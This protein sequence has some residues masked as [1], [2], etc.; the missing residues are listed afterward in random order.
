MMY[1]PSHIVLET[2]NITRK[3][4]NNIYPVSIMQMLRTEVSMVP[5]DGWDNIVWVMWRLCLRKRHRVAPTTVLFI[6]VPPSPFIPSSP[7]CLLLLRYNTKVSQLHPPLQIYQHI[8]RLDITMQHPLKMKIAQS[9]YYLVGNGSN[10]IRYQ[11]CRLIPGGTFVIVHECS[12]KF[13]FYQAITM[14]WA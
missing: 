5:H 11:C 6:I 13:Y 7:C 4:I 14:E 2:A 10:G 12:L 3:L 8:H 9:P 1:R